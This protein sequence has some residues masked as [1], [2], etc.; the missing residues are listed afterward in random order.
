MSEQRTVNRKQEKQFRRCSLVTVYHPLAAL[1]IAILAG[2]AGKDVRPERAPESAPRVETRPAPQPAQEPTIPAPEPEQS[3]A[4]YED[5][6]PHEVA[7]PNLSEVPDAEPKTE[8]LH[9]YANRPY[10]VLGKSYMPDEQRQAYRE[11]GKASWYGRKFHGNRTSSGEVYD[12]YAMTAAHRTLAIPSYVRITHVDSQKSVVVRVNDRGPFHS[13]RIID[14]SYTAAHK[15]G[16]VNA[17][18]SLVEVE[19]VDPELSEILAKRDEQNVKRVY[20]QVGAFSGKKQAES[21]LSR[22]KSQ[23]GPVKRA[24]EIFVK[25]GLFKV[26]VG[27]YKDKKE[28]NAEANQIGKLLRLKPVMVVR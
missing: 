3:G 11:R 8:P 26:H 10:A 5:D 21:Y 4:Y 2:C 6:G 7:P 15:L 20:L 9:P 24:L 17:G 14:L 12:M 16:M 18:T 23:L 22:A 28:A 25:D 1:G 27:P 19:A 13:D